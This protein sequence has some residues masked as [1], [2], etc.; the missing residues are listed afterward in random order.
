[1]DAETRTQLQLQPAEVK[2]RAVTGI[3][4]AGGRSKRMGC[5]KAWVEIGGRPLVQWV[6][7]AMGPIAS[8]RMVVSRA[9]GRLEN[10]GVPVVVDRFDARGPLTG[11]HAGLS[12]ASHEVCLVVACDMPLVRTDLLAYL[13]DAVAAANAA[14]PYVGEGELPSLG[15]VDSVHGV[16]LQPLLAAYRRCCAPLLAEVLA[17]G[18]PPTTALTSVLDARVV[19][20]EEW[21]AADPD[22]RSFFN[23]DTYEDLIQAV[24]I[25]GAT[26]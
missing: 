22:G 14:V 16:G 24:R 26:A 10:L 2:S 23:I 15:A 9:V 1:M 17:G 6:L 20:P 3:V 13:V 11:I 4:L 7:D 19:H 18:S 8:E 25:L 5:N 12:A 21:R